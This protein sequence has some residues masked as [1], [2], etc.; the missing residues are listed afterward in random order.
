MTTT[1]YFDLDR[2]EAAIFTSYFPVFAKNRR[3]CSRCGHESRFE[4][5]CLRK[6][7]SRNAR[8]CDERAGRPRNRQARA[9]WEGRSSFAKCST[10][11]TELVA[12]AQKSDSLILSRTECFVSGAL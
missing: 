10:T 2:S 1:S 11:M 12:C 7:P 5:S 6:L 8:A 4:I 9:R 3:D